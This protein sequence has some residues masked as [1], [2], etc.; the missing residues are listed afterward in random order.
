MKIEVMQDE[1]AD[2][3]KEVHN[4][5]YIGTKHSELV[6]FSEKIGFYRLNNTEF[7]AYPLMENKFDMYSLCD[8]EKMAS[9]V[10][11]I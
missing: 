9:I 6:Y 3:L 10:A 5:G 7:I 8:G 2:F 1:L 11:S 4:G